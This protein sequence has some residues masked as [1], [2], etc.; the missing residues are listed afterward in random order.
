VVIGE[1]GHKP[2]VELDLTQLKGELPLASV[3][4]GPGISNDDSERLVR[5][6]LDQHGFSHVPIRRSGASLRIQQRVVQ[7]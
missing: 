7:L 1:R 5:G 6:F 2:H 3:R 4:L